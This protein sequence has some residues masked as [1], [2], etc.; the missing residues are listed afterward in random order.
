MDYYEP[1]DRL[2][3]WCTERPGTKQHYLREIAGIA[4]QYEVYIH[5]S[6]TSVAESV[7]S[8]GIALLETQYQRD[9][10]TRMIRLRACSSGLLMLVAGDPV[11]TGVDEYASC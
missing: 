2:L 5:E 4:D 1:I 11:D 10:E 9:L 8:D 3:D 6:D 7:I